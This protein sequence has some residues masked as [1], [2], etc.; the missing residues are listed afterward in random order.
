MPADRQHACVVPDMPF[1]THYRTNLKGPPFNPL[2]PIPNITHHV[3]K[4]LAHTWKVSPIWLNITD[5]Y[6]YIFILFP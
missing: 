3:L 2:I 6:I 1:I 5:I 4:Y